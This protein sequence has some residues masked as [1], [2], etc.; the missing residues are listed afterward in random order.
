MPASARAIQYAADVAALP[1]VIATIIKGVAPKALVVPQWIFDEN[2][3]RW[4]GMLRSKDDLDSDNQPRV[5]AICVYYDGQDE[6]DPDF[7]R[8]VGSFRPVIPIGIAF[9]QQFYLGTL[10]DNAE[11]NMAIETSIVKFTLSEN[12]TLGIN[13]IAGHTGIRIPKIN[14]LPLGETNCL[15]GRSTLKVHM[16]PRQ[17]RG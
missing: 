3:E 11:K 9:Y 7:S 17:T 10:A 6:A 12:K 16:D 5:H 13:G 8:I 2:A 15:T 1:G 4:A 14:F